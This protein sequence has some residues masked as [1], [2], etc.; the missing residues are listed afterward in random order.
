MIP[1]RELV[2]N[3]G[4]AIPCLKINTEENDD[5]KGKLTLFRKLVTCEDSGLTS[6]RHLPSPGEARG[7]SRGRHG[8]KEGV[9]MQAVSRM[10]T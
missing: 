9:W 3:S 5:G 7:F 6:Q 1:D 2:L 8:K 10:Q 4:S